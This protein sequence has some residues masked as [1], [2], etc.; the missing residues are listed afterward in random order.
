MLNKLQLLAINEIVSIFIIVL[1]STTAFADETCHRLTYAGANEW[2]PISYID[3]EGIYQGLIHDIMQAAV[4]PLNIELVSSPARPW[5]RVMDDLLK[6][7][8]DAIFGAYFNKEREK[9]FVYSTPVFQDHIKLFVH[10]DN[11]FPFNSLVDLIGKSGVRPFGGSYGDEFDRFDRENLNLSQIKS[12]YLMMKMVQKERVDYAVFA[13][14]DG[15]AAIKSMGLSKKI[16]P[17]DKEVTQ[18]VIYVLFSKQSAC[19]NKLAAINNEINNLKK[20]G[21]ISKFYRYYL[22]TIQ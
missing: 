17:I 22:K 18:L 14:F 3:D 9:L 8:I 1:V 4:E 10:V 15:L 13:E 20:K 7:K 21:T 16:V 2:Q 11:Q 6:N 19:V 12:H 5:K